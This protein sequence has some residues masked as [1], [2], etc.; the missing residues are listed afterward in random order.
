MLERHELDAFVILAEELHFGRTAERLG[1]STTRISQTIR[2]LE[3]RVGVP[4]FDRTSRRVA[5]TAAG[6]Q[7]HDDIQ[8]AWA[9]IAAGLRRAVEAGRGMT[10]E[11]LVGFVGAAGG[12][13]ML[14]V[15]EVFRR[16]HPDCDVRIREA[17]IAEVMPWLHDGGVDVAL[18]PFPVQEPLLEAGRVLVREARVLAVSSQHPFARRDSVSVEDLAEV[19]VLTLPATLPASLRRDRTPDSTPN[20]RPI[21]SGPPAVTFQEALMLVGSGQGVLPVGAHVRRYYVRPDVTYVHFRDAPPVE[22]G[23]AWHRDRATARVLA[24]ARAA[25]DLVDRQE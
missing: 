18:T 22:W 16:R 10:G 15:S 4:L 8:P 3:R 11:L 23:L 19:P 20:G 9:Q 12:Q 24:F 17:Q 2:K 1:V 14:R 5:L 6:R 25:E 13:L 21:P 7:L